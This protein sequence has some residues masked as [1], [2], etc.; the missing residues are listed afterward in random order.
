[1]HD[2]AGSCRALGTCHF[3]DYQRSVRRNLALRQLHLRLPH[4]KLK[5]SLTFSW[6]AHA[7]LNHVMHGSVTPCRVQVLSDQ[8]DCEIPARCSSALRHP[9]L[10]LSHKGFKPA[11]TS[12]DTT[13]GPHDARSYELMQEFSNNTELPVRSVKPSHACARINSNR[14]MKTGTKI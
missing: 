12:A 2:S 13:H 14:D 9:H 5:T 6:P 10:R 8:L 3:L 4:T 11:S 1:M 7:I